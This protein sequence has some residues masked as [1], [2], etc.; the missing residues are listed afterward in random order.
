VR[1]LLREYGCR[2][3]VVR[4]EREPDPAPRP[5]LQIWL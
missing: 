4:G 5:Y 2:S 1:V 3:C